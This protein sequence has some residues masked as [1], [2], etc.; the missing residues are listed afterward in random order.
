MYRGWAQVAFFRES[1][2]DLA[3]AEFG[4]VPLLLVRRGGTVTAY[5]ATCPH[6]GA[7]LGYGGRLDD[8]VVVCP[9]HGRRIRLGLDG[10]DAYCVTSY[11]TFEAGGSV[12]VLLDE[13]H[14]HGFAA[15]MR[16]VAETHFVLP[17]F[18]LPARIAPEYVIENVFDVDHFKSV[19]AVSSR[20]RLHWRSGD[21]GELIVEGSF[22]LERPNKW[23]GSASEDEEVAPMHFRAR[24]FSPTLVATEL[25]SPEA[26]NVVVTSATPTPKGDCVIRVTIAMARLPDGTAPTVLAVGSLMSGTRTAFEQDLEIW[27]HLDRAAPSHF[28]PSDELVLAYHD[29]CRRFAGPDEV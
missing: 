7:H 3:P 28:A 10:R 22:E 23:Q 18:E 16:G 12:Y 29:F 24:V 9:F 1:D 13:L 14:D 17:G 27:E 2:G 4:A 19:H 26:P 20:P 11:P 8:G 25:G 5:H 6:R 15:F 21:D